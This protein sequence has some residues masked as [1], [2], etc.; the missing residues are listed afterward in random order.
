VTTAA[1]AA[2]TLCVLDTLPCLLEDARPLLERAARTAT[3][4]TLRDRATLIVARYAEAMGDVES[5]RSTLRALVGRVRGQGTRLECSAWFNVAWVACTHGEHLP[6]LTFARRALELMPRAGD[7][8]G[9][10]LVR[11]CRAD[12]YAAL[13][14]AERF[15]AEMAAA[16]SIARTLPPALAAPLA[17]TIEQSRAAEFVHRGEAQAALDALDRARAIDP[18][19]VEDDN[20][21]RRWHLLRADA[22]V[23]L[24]RTKEAAAVLA[25][26]R[27]MG[28]FRDVDDVDLAFAGI[29]YR[30]AHGG[31]AAA[32]SPAESVLAML[33]GVGAA[34]VAPARRATMVSDLARLLEDA[35]APPALVECAWDMAARA[36]LAAIRRVSEDLDAHPE[37]ALPHPED[38][39]PMRDHARRSAEGRAPLFEAAA[40]AWRAD[41]AAGDAV[42]DEIVGPAGAIHVC[43]WCLRLRRGDG[44]WLPL[45]GFAP[46]AGSPRLLH[47]TCDGC[48]GGIRGDIDRSA[49]RRKSQF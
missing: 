37:L 44:A 34:R 11:I 22:L 20:R 16:E 23:V 10:A 40:R 30:L 28:P 15:A 42:L 12:V 14:D 47:G 48:A 29:R 13:D 2:R 38:L 3:D 26:A 6:S 9:E 5:A 31:P 49:T 18:G 35:K 43:A 19:T 17:F 4:P 24:G 7:A 21:G 27:A 8:R 46:P 25:R 1:G 32:W 36:V 33:D 45:T 41:H 39:A